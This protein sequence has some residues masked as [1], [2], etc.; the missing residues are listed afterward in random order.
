MDVVFPKNKIWMEKVPTKIMFFAWE[1]T[2]GKILTLDRLQKRGWQLPNRCFLCAC[3]AESVNQI[4]IHCTVARVLWDL[5]LGLVG[6]KW[7]FPNTV[8]EVLYSGGGCFCGEKKE[9]V[10]EFHSIIY[11]LDGLKGKE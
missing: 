2:W 7:V 5:V 6:V 1:A 10:L 9:K 8:K 4:L 11:F 3:E